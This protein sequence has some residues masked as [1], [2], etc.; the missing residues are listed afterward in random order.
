[1]IFFGLSCCNLMQFFVSEINLIKLHHG[2]SVEFNLVIK[3]FLLISLQKGLP[4]LLRRILLL[5]SHMPEYSISNVTINFHV[6]KLQENCQF[7]EH[8]DLPSKISSA[9]F[10]ISFVSL[11]YGNF[12]QKLILEFD[13]GNKLLRNI[14]IQ[15]LPERKLMESFWFGPTEYEESELS[16]IKNHTITPFY[17]EAKIGGGLFQLACHVLKKQYLLNDFVAPVLEVDS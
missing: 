12:E 2:I 3:S 14:G 7:W 5:E 10:S 6:Q 8:C 17:G 1:M 13:K 11:S 4:I 9:Q 16:W 15:V